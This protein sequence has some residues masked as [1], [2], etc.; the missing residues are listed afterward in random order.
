MIFVDQ[1]SMQT[2]L[3]IF[4]CL[5][6]DYSQDVTGIFDA[7]IAAFQKHDLLFFLQKIIFL[8]SDG[9]SVNSRH[10]SGLLF[11]LHKDREW[12]TFICFSH[13]L[14]LTLKDGLKMHTPPV[15]KSL[16]HLFYLYKNSSK[17]HRELKNL[18]QLTKGQFEMHGDGVGGL[19]IAGTRW[20]D[21]KICAIER[22]V[23]KYGLYCLHLQHAITDTKKSKDRVTLQGKFNKLVDAKIL[24]HSSFSIDVRTFISLQTQKSVISIIDF[25]ECVATKEKLQKTTKTI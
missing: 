21:H 13:R 2:T 4:E 18:Y 19:K 7:M 12:I 5:G 14:E 24:L 8:C 3:E 25:A 20:I 10:D 15:D 11:L 17:K 1:D 9:T 16:M 23:N 22:V 6:L